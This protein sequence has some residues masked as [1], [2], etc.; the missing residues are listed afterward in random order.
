MNLP[1]TN[2]IWITHSKKK[3][4]QPGEVQIDEYQSRTDVR[5]VKSWKLTWLTKIPK[6]TKIQN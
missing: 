4:K 1:L 5:K 2:L 6:N 3:M